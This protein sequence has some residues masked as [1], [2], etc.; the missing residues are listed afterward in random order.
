VEESARK[1]DENGWFG[2]PAVGWYVNKDDTIAYAKALTA[3]PKI[4][5]DRAGRPQAIFSDFT[6]WR[7]VQWNDCS[8]PFSILS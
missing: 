4:A 3:L 6:K 2:K 1:L 8:Y 5:S 7:L